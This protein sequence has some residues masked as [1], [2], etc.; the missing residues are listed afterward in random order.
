ML[1]PRLDWNGE[2]TWI[3]R[4]TLKPPNYLP[5]TLGRRREPSRQ[6]IP[7]TLS[8]R[9]KTAEHPIVKVAPQWRARCIATPLT[10][11]A[12]PLDT[13]RLQKDACHPA[14]QSQPRNDS[15]RFSPTC[16]FRV[17][18]NI[19]FLYLPTQPS[20]WQPPMAPQRALQPSQALSTSS[21]WTT[22]WTHAMPAVATLS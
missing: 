1:S 15:H 2:G 19:I 21:T 7:S 20:S 22:T 18:R 14:T 11:T 10:T 3:P 8:D 6:M 17:T 13:D 16:H 5:A 9:S 12:R 4:C